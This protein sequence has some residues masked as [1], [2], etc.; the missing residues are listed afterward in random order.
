MIRQKA[1]RKPTAAAL[2]PMTAILRCDSGSE[3]VARAITTALSP[4]SRMSMP[5]IRNRSTRNRAAVK[6]KNLSSLLWPNRELSHARGAVRA[7]I[8]GDAYICAIC[9]ATYNKI[10]TVPPDSTRLTIAP[11]Q[12][13]F[14]LGAFLPSTSIGARL[15]RCPAASASR[16]VTAA[17]SIRIVTGTEQRSSRT[18]SSS[19]CRAARHTFVHAAVRS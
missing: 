16:F 19:S 1:T 12:P 15:P 17:V 2:P 7:A 18:R 14:E 3:R 6:W 13:P 5:V 9:S 8:V 10:G 11:G 4:D